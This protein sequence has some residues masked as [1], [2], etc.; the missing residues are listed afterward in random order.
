MDKIITFNLLVEVSIG[1]LQI[2]K[3]IAIILHLLHWPAKSCICKALK[4]SS[5]YKT[6]TIEKQN[7]R[8]KNKYFKAILT[9][10]IKK[11]YEA[12]AS[13]NKDYYLK[14]I[15]KYH[16]VLLAYDRNAIT[17]VELSASVEC[18]YRWAGNFELRRNHFAWFSRCTFV[19]STSLCYVF[20]LLHTSLFFFCFTSCNY[21]LFPPV[22]T[23]PIN[24]EIDRTRLLNRIWSSGY[25]L[26]VERE[27][28][29]RRV[30]AIAFADVI[31]G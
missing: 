20:I 4:P 29:G 15:F 21:V 17:G 8:K 30:A 14:Y 13:W 7:L 28:L 5:Y 19:L 24:I 10:F 22:H 1:F 11:Y 27:R 2:E 31:F 6:N 16:P 25:G 3:Y 12:K 23:S 18:N 26:L 9:L